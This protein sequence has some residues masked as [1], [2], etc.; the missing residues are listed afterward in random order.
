MSHL[1]DLIIDLTLILAAAALIMLV[2]K[3]LKQPLVLG[4]IIAGF[5]VGPYVQW[6]PTVKEVENIKIWAEIGVIFLLFSLGL[7]FS[8]KKLMKVGPSASVT[9]LIEVVVMVAI[10]FGIGRALGWSSMDSLFL[11]GILSISS[12]T[13]IIRAFDEL[14]LKTR[15]FATLVFGV[16][17]VEDLVAILLLVLLSTLAVSRQ[18]SG[19]E[20]LASL[21][22]LIFFLAIWFLSGIFLIPS[23]LRR[24]KKLLTDEILLVIAVALCLLM[25]LFADTVGFSPALG[26][27]IMGSILA[28]TTKAEKIEHLIRP[29]KD[30]FAAIFFVSVGML[31]DP[32][33]IVEYAGPIALLCV[34]TIVGKVLST[35]IG[36]LL[37]GQ[38]LQTSIQSGFSLAQIGEF[39]FIIATLGLTLKVTSDFLYPIAVAVSAVT[40]LTTPY[41]I[42]SSNVVF[43]WVDKR[44]PK[45]MLDA[46]SSR[47]SETKDISRSSDW[48][49]YLRSTFLN[50]VLFSLVIL[51]I[52]FIS[53]TYLLPRISITGNS[54][55]TRL[56]V[57]AGTLLALVP[58]LWALAI[59]NA[60]A[61]YN[62]VAATNR[63]NGLIK[64]LHFFRLVIAALFIGFLLHRFFGFT[65]GA[66]GTIITIVLLLLFSKKIQLLYNRIEK[67]FV[68]N[69]N[70]REIAKAESN[71]TELAPWDAGI[72]PVGIQSDASCIGKR[73]IDLKWREKA[74][75]NV[76]MIKRGYHTISAPGKDE[77]IFPGDELLVLGTDIQIKKLEALIRPLKNKANANGDNDEVA[78]HEFTI[79][80]GSALVGMTIRGSGIREQYNGLV[81]GVERKGQR[82]LN[83]ESDF[84]FEVN[85][86]VFIVGVTKRLI[87][88]FV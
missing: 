64:M 82:T 63:Y 85:D 35:S 15:R 67:Q 11:G 18:F 14:G 20:M 27:F 44:L 81:V 56:I 3:R 41:L 73:L 61:A 34:V 69:L 38:S 84:V 65:A 13:I 5:L 1:S 2:F 7:E 36:A 53:S 77:M 29:V 76:V 48:N 57:A 54:L 72:I 19:V 66:I 42:R 50:I 51:S 12:T 87:G 59:R 58:F 68:T 9:A 46:I 32:G 4:Y 22:K 33:V 40:T 21:S 86:V 6:L 43:K 74:G 55:T 71:R 16:L 49:L 78:L 83:P 62:K 26:A 25:V 75:I 70:Q 47:S 88:L 23:L 10:G 17:I 30:L 52:I 39:S 60:P 31:I 8:F 24:A 79:T 28:E 37:A 45:R 80:P